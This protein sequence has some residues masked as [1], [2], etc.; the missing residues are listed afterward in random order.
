MNEGLICGRGLSAGGL[1]AGGGVICGEMQCAREWGGGICG[2]GLICEG[3]LIRVG[4]GGGGFSAEL[5]GI[6]QSKI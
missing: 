2:G 5:Y 1:S 3:G 6:I 4:R